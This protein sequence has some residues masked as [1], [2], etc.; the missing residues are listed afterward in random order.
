MANDRKTL[1]VPIGF[2]FP[3]SLFPISCFPSVYGW[4][5]AN[6]ANDRTNM[7]CF[8]SVLLFLSVV[9]L[10]VYGWDVANMAT[11]RKTFVVS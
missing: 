5:V 7:F 10:V 2:V 8:L 6:M 3:I 9:L 1:V 11:D 4:D